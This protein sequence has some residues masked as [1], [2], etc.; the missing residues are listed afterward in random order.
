MYM[1]KHILH[2]PCV[3]AEA[4][5]SSNEFEYF[6]PFTFFMNTILIYQKEAGAKNISISSC[7][8]SQTLMCVL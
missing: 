1:A 5:F 7:P 4:A 8:S 3:W 6:Y 2:F